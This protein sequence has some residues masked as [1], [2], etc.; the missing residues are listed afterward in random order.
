M[1]PSPEELLKTLMDEVPKDLNVNDIQIGG[2]HYKSEY[3]HWDMIEEHGIGYLEAA[4]SK[5]VC[6][7]RDKGTPVKDLTKALHYTE[8]LISL[9]SQ[10]IR[11]ARGT[12]PVGDMERFSALNRLTKL[13]H[14]AV[15]WLVQWFCAEDLVKARESILKLLNEATADFQDREVDVDPGQ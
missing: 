15:S 1:G 10:G 7:W 14:T 6:R 4:A 8:K 9:H 5:Y 12:V 3:Q 2:D 11:N 13:E